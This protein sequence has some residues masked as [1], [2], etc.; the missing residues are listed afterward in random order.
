MTAPSVDAGALDAVA[1]R[2]LLGSAQ[3]ALETAIAFGPNAVAAWCQQLARAARAL[4]EVELATVAAAAASA[5]GDGGALA[6]VGRRLC[7]EGAPATAALLLACAH[8]LAPD[9]EAVAHARVSA[10]GADGRHREACRVLRELPSWMAAGRESRALLAWHALL[11]GDLDEPR[12]LL[13]ELAGSPAPAHRA[14]AD[15]LRGML[16]RADAA[17]T[18]SSLDERDL[19]GWHFVITGGLLLTRSSHGA[20][21]MNGRHGFVHD[22]HRDCLAGLRRAAAVMTAWDQPVA[23]VLAPADRDSAILACAAGMILGCRV[24]AWSADRAGLITVYDVD[25]LTPAQRAS[26]AD[27]RPGQVLYS[28]AASWTAQPAFAA[29]L[30]A[31]VHQIGLA[32]WDA[33]RGLDPATGT[34]REVPADGA[35]I[36]ELAAR[37]ASA[38]LTADDL[39]DLPALLA[40]AEAARTLTGDDAAGGLRVTGRRRPAWTGTPVASVRLRG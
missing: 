1:A 36:A 31:R 10:L 28:H 16:A 18:S 34:L 26:L 40:L 33:A 21:V 4:G 19:R 7:V 32:P 23:R 25:R 8:R 24:E 9:D 11:A 20:A 15:E 6:A 17:R 5:R 13:P 22:D 29:D 37:V 3:A 38:A 39:A 2:D 14:R 12:R 27:H 30:V 35:P